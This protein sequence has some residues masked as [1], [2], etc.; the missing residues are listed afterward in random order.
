MLNI[1]VIK[2]RYRLNP[3]PKEV[4][5]VRKLITESFKKLEFVEDVHKYFLPTRGGKKIELP[6]VSSVI[7]QWIPFVDWDEQ[8][9]L[10]A[11]KLGITKEEMLRQWHENKIRSTSC[12]SKTHWFG[13]NAMNMFIGRE[14]LTKA[15]MPFQYTEDGY[16]IPYCGKEEAVT[17]Y[18]EDILANPDVYPVMPEAKIYTNYNKK[19]KLKKP[20]A[21]TFDILL[22]YRYK[23]RIVF[24][25]HDW[26]GLP[27]DTKIL[28]T[29]GF[30][31][32][33]DLSVGDMV[34]DRDGNA[35]SVI[36][37][38][39]VHHKPCIEFTFDDNTTM[40][41][42]HEHRWLVS[43]LKRDK[44]FEEKV[45]TSEEIYSYLL[46]IEKC[47][48]NAGNI[49]K[50][51]INKPLKNAEIKPL[52]ID[53]YVLGVWL[54]DGATKSGYVT[55]M[56][57][58][59]FSEIEKRGYHVGEN[60]DKRGY[61]GKAKTRCVFGL[62]TKLKE[63]GILGNKDIPDAFLINSTYEQ[64]LDILRGLMDTDGTYNKARNRYVIS[65]TK[66][67]QVDFTVKLLASLGIKPSVSAFK[68][69]CKDCKKESYDAWNVSF[70]TDEYPFL[71]RDIKVDGT[72]NGR[73]S[74]RNIVSAKYVE[75]VPTKCIE[76]DSPTHTYLATEKLIVTHNTNKDIYKDYSRAKGIMMLEPFESMGFFEEAYSHYCIQLS[77]YQIGLMQ[78]G[79]EIVDRNLIWLKDDGTYEKVKTPDLTQTIISELS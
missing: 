26:K 42:D 51:R 14:D 56:Y 77:M 76:V 69:K 35:V 37:I 63:C 17:K 23:G 53:P 40:V 15:N 3:E 36:N 64:R 20:Y 38:S 75:T 28:T 2:E 71:I 31:T 55:N 50:I 25:I 57:D 32:M 45:M 21:G 58:A 13:E 27:L 79:L 44:S 73:Y 7:E 30:K 43:F 65:T 61:C 70:I 24:A 66:R 12:G 39:S 54:G 47:G 8:A 16:L 41:S 22:A 19:F 67:N 10:K 46:K 49:P 59:I 4:T 6:S 48:R 72:R 68:A 29:N 74:Y 78:L 52:P 1:D 11:V 34:Y 5:E 62:F 9:G 18:Y 33:G 60:V